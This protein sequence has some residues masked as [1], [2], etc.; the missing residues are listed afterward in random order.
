[1]TLFWIIESSP[2]MTFFSSPIMTEDLRRLRSK[3]VRWFYQRSHS[4]ALVEVLETR[5]GNLISTDCRIK[6]NI[7]L[8]LKPLE[9]KIATW[10]KYKTNSLFAR[11]CRNFKS[12][13]FIIIRMRKFNNIGSDISVGAKKF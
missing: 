7:L 5:H 9:I 6:Y 10:Q 2:T 13:F 12:F 1:M 3:L 4:R 11:N 8:K